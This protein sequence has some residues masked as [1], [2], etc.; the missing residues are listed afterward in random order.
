MK[1]TSKKQCGLILG[2]SC[3]LATINTYADT[4]EISFPDISKSYL[5]QVQRYS[6]TT[7]A[8][9]DVGLTKD[10]YRHILGN[11]QFNEGIFFVKTW[12]YV[13]DIHK[14]NSDEYKRC[15]LRIDFDKHNIGERLSWKGEECQG[16]MDWGVNNTV[17]PV[18]VIAPVVKA[19]QQAYVLFAYDKSDV[20]SIE[21]T[22]LSLQDIATKIKQAS[23]QEVKIT[24]YTDPTGSYSYNQKLSEQRAYTVA[25]QLVS[26]GVSQ[27]VIDVT[28]ANKTTSFEQCKGEQRQHQSV[29][30]NAPNRRVVIDWK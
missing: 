15:Q 16:L 23:A 27:N 19:P 2:L 25:K 24:G 9:L 11:P 22:S 4:A 28:A 21:Q 6:Y 30:C 3:M 26:L 8:N 5:K 13:L 29:S 12:N 18:P 7:V 14:P 1:M 17:V 20:Q 10:Q